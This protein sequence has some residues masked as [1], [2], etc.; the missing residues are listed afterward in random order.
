MSDNKF[1]AVSSFLDMQEMSGEVIEH[2]KRSDTLAQTYGRYQLYGDIMRGDSADVI[3]PDLADDIAMAIAI[4]PT[5][6]APQRKAGLGAWAKAKVIQLAKPAG[7][8][9]IAASAAGLMVLGVQQVN[10]NNDEA[11]IPTQTWQPLPIG[12]VADPVSYNYPQRT[13][14][15]QRQQAINHHQKLQ[16]LLSDHELQLKWRKQTDETQPSSAEDS[17]NLDNND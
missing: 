2:M 10:T 4:E 11:L 9:A 17:N 3:A 8:M 12:G 14:T 5:V 16:S 13:A 15:E 1:E 6:L 7:Q